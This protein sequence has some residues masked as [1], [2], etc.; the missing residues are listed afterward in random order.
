MTALQTDRAATLLSGELA[1]AKTYKLALS[2]AGVDPKASVLHRIYADHEKAAA[3]LRELGGSEDRK[4]EFDTIFWDSFGYATRGSNS[5][6]HNPDALET[7]RIGEEQCAAGYAYAAEDDQLTL[8]LRALIRRRLLPQTQFH[9]ATL[10][11]LA[12][13]QRSRW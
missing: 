13:G 1:A 5:L 12:E 6:S 10:E 7:L 11:R 2:K 8:E 3:T 9:I 4:Q